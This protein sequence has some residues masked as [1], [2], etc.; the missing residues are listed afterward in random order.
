M[1]VLSYKCLIT[2]MFKMK[3]YLE[4][5]MIYF[6]FFMIFFHF[7]FIDQINQHLILYLVT[8]LKTFFK[9]QESYYVNFYD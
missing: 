1:K 4:F 7:F 6:C 3:V 2:L 9:L 5:E 8:F